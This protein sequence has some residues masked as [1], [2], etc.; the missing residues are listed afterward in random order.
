M[1]LLATFRYTYYIYSIYYILIKHI[2]LKLYYIIFT[3]NKL[4]YIILC[5]RYLNEK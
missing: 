4:L 5:D 2:L 1:I 3:I